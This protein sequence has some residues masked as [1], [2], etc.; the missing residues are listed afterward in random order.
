MN[1][2]QEFERKLDLILNKLEIRV[3]PTNEPEP[4]SIQH[5]RNLAK[6]GKEIEAIKV[7]RQYTGAS[8][9]DAKDFVEGM[10]AASPADSYRRLDEK[11][12]LILNRL[13]IPF[14]A[15]PPDN[16]LYG[17]IRS[18]LW[19]GKKIEAVKLYRET[20]NLGLKEAKDAV[21]AIEKEMR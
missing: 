21:D 8:L 2:L 14:V 9:R 16:A 11:I 13:E 6:Q 15:P 7:Y 12:N 18:L 17:E 20:F 3:N 19:A 4:E 10:R 5:V 1:Y